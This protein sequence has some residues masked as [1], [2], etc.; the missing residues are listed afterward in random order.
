MLHFWGI[1]TF[2][3]IIFRYLP[4]II[5][6]AGRT[7]RQLTDGS[8][9]QLAI[10]AAIDILIR[11]L[12]YPNLLKPKDRS[13]TEKTLKSTSLGRSKYK[14]HIQEESKFTAPGGIKILNMPPRAT[15]EMV[16][17]TDLKK[18]LENW[19]FHRDRM[20]RCGSFES[21]NS[22]TQNLTLK[23]FLNPEKF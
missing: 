20:R 15:N 8:S 2:Y 14:D 6:F 21:K 18:M 10:E 3:K 11:C 7:P 23:N 17:G 12:S 13:L 16:I 5:E 22:E 19:N 1:K 4:D 9:D